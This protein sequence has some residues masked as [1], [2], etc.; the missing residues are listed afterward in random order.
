MTMRRLAGPIFLLLLATVVFVGCALSSPP[1]RIP[2]GC[3]ATSPAEAASPACNTV[4]NSADWVVVTNQLGTTAP[5]PQGG[6]LADGLYECKKLETYG[7]GPPAR[8]EVRET[9]A[10][11]QEGTTLL[12]ASDALNTDTN[13]DETYHAN[14]SAV[15]SGDVVT[16]TDTC[17]VSI[18]PLDDHDFSVTSD[19]FL[20]FDQGDPLLWVY[21]FTRSRC[22]GVE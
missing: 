13:S 8:L 16:F 12:W 19:G 17:G 18:F 3:S 15:A 9:V 5:D 20:L 2:S 22:S 1:R 4:S 10:V 7:T 6:V 21:T 11:T 14:V